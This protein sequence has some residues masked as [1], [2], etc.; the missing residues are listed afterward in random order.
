MKHIDGKDAIFLYMETPSYHMHMAFAGVLDPSTIP[1]GI[2][3]PR[4][5]YNHI[6][7]LIV[8]RLHVFP[9][10]RQRLMEVPFRLHHPVFVEDPAFD[11]DF[12]IRR[13]ALPSPGGKRELEDFVSQVL[14][15]PMDRN[16]PL[17]EMYVVEGVEGGRWAMVAKAHHVL[18]D[19]V[20][21]N[22][23]MVNLMDLTPE[24]REVD[25]PEKP[26][27]PDDPP[28]DLKLLGDALFA[29]LK[30]PPRFVKQVARSATTLV[31]VARD[32]VSG[33]DEAA[34]AT[35]GPKTMFNQVVTPH[36]RVGFGRFELED[37][38]TVKN[39]FGCTV[40]D[41]VLA[42]CG[43]ALRRYLEEHGESPDRSLVA[44]VP[45][46]IRAGE[47]ESLGNRVAAMTVPMADEVD[48]PTEQIRRIREVTKSAKERL[49]AITADLMMD[50]TQFATPAL[51]A[52]AFRFYT[53]SRIQNL[54]RP[55]ANVT[56]SNVPG[57]PFPI[58]VAGSQLQSF[59]PLGP[60]VLG[61]GVNITV[62][63]YLG[64]MY[65]GVVGCPETTPNIESVADGISKALD[66]FVEAAAALEK[67][68]A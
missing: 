25:P 4:E 7:E 16:R 64:V 20:G 49:G 13:A 31:K 22:E 23:M 10:F 32:K 19:G 65:V 62:V 54:H 63:S 29:N 30:Q 24:P 68:K 39:A 44:S 14:S 66:E 2:K 60:I 52:R 57:P 12:H 47:E 1:G 38:K 11:L 3:E 58:Y 51:A 8:D 46:S 41:V 59:Y 6:K 15:R 27:E 42:V 61:Q 55:V 9:P 40:N 43:R 36:R 53:G 35:M 5:V 56:I 21:G 45:I 17:W 37:I 50:W 18:I 34:I 28:G 48:D 67:A 26:W 33:E